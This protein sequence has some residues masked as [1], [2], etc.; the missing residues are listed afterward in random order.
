MIGA[1]DLDAPVILDFESI[2]LG[3][4]GQYE[5]DLVQLFKG[6]PLV[7]KLEDGKY[8]IDIPSTFQLA[9]KEKEEKKN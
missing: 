8:F 9:R 6:E 4:P 2:K 1:K 5:L 7:Y 3:K